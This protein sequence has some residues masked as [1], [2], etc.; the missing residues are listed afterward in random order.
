MSDAFFATSVPPFPIAI[1]ISAF[2]NAGL[3]F[4]P[5]PVIAT[6]APVFCHA[7]T[8][9]TL[10][11]GVTLANTAYS[12][13]VFSNCSCGIL[14]NSCPVIAL[15]FLDNIPNFSAIAFAV[16]IWSP[17]IITVFIPAFLQVSTASFT[18]SLGGSNI[19]ISPTKFKLFSMFIL[20]IFVGKFS[21][22]LYATAITLKAF[23]AICSFSISTFFLS[24]FKHLFNNISGAP[25]VIILYFPLFNLCIVVIIFLLESN[26]ISLILGIIL[27]KSCLFFPF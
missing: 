7:F 23:L 15:S 20:S 6:T 5:S 2:F 26:G 13:I 12:F 14:S 1:P 21:I 24:T 11:S 18:P 17:V 16:S 3:S 8:I 4:T 10:C 19:P 22:S 9:L 25:F 27:Y